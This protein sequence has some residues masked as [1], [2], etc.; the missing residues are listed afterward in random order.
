MQMKFLAVAI[1]VVLTATMFMVQAIS[2]NAYAVVAGAGK[3]D[4]VCA[5]AVAFGN[6]AK[7]KACIGGYC[8]SAGGR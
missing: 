2:T 3:C 1:L 5:I 6:F 4:A 7:A 8:I